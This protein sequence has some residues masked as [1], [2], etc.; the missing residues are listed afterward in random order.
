MMKEMN[1]RTDEYGGN[2]ENMSRFIVEIADEIRSV[3]G[4]D[5]P[6]LL[7]FAAQHHFK[8]GRTLEETIELMKIFDKSEIDAF[9]IDSGCYETWD[10][11]FPPSYLGDAPSMD[12]SAVLKQ[13]T[14]KPILITNN[15]TPDCA[16]E[17]LERNQADY[18]MI[19]RGLIADPELPNKVLYNKADEVRPCIR[20]NECINSVF[21]G[22]RPTCS[23]NAQALQEKE[24]S[25][26]KTDTPKKVVIIGGGPGGLE[27]ARV[28]ATKGHLVTLYEKNMVLGGQL[29][30]AAT[31]TF[32][33]Q[34]RKYLDYL[35]LQVE[36]LKVTVHTN[37]EITASS[38]ELKEAD[39]IIVA[40]GATAVIPK[41]S[42]INKKNVIEVLEAHLSRHDEIKNNVV[43]AG[44]GLSGCDCALELAMEGKNVT[45]V[46]LLSDVA[47]GTSPFNRLTLMSKLDEY[48]VKKLTHSKVVQ[49]Q[50]NGVFVQNLSGEEALIE[51]ET[52]IVS[53]GTKS[54]KSLVDAICNKYPTAKSIG[55][56]VEIGQVGETVRAGFFAAWAID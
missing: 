53:F 34:L 33:S 8:L 36:K 12:D 3:V 39:E 10:W 48:G 45:I 41:I 54:C 49:F 5:Y 30:A 42:G 19:G 21:S 44:G 17:A 56:C 15:I 11:M 26:K 14:N 29:A 9:D 46:E 6:I 24:F 16:A 32:K 27:A 35:I 38:N 1:H 31:P 4:P 2:Y 50:E 7:R 18:F 28:A 40:V 47:L 20:C 23:V 22:L 37:T 13:Y 43:I 52:M 55:D 25:L 51:A